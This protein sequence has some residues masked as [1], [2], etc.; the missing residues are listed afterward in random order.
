M[1]RSSRPVR[2]T[3]PSST[4]TTHRPRRRPVRRPEGV[5]AHRALDAVVGAQHGL[6]QVAARDDTDEPI[7]V[8][9][10]AVITSPAV[11]ARRTPG[12]LL[13]GRTHQGPG[14]PPGPAARG[15]VSAK[16]DVKTTPMTRSCA[17]VTGR[18]STWCSPSER[19]TS[20]SGV[21]CAAVPPP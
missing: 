14:V 12:I 8:T 4:A 21:P 13:T 1:R 5:P 15:R 20:L 17:S 19:T 2:V 6:R 18:P 11:R 10:G 7:L 3:T 9:A 16:S